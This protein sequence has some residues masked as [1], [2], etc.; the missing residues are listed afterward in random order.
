MQRPCMS[1]WGHGCERRAS[2]GSD[3]LT[4]NPKGIQR[5][6]PGFGV[7]IREAGYEVS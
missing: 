5:A 4:H 3:S 6:S 2:L 1:T 7:T